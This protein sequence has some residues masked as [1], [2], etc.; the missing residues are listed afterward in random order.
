MVSSLQTAPMSALEP[1]L[2]IYRGMSVFD[3]SVQYG[4]WTGT[5]KADGADQNAIGQLLRQRKL[6]RSGEFLVGLEVWV[7]ENHSGQPLAP[8]IYAYLVEAVS[9]DQA[10]MFIAEHNPVPVR[11]VRIDNMTLDEFVAC[12]KR[13]S[14][15]FGWRDAGFIGRE[16]KE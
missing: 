1:M 15:A 8:T 5:A 10:Q 16:Y 4:D 9:L 7:G 2:G 12:F 3:A 6:M 13:F 14:I 11:R